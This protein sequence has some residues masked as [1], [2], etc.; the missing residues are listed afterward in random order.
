[1]VGDGVRAG[2]EAVLEQPLAQG[3]DLVLDVRRGPVGDP[4]G[5]PRTGRDR[6][7]PPER[8]RQ[9]SLATQDMDTP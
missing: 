1:V 8:Y 7:K 2:V 4:A 6:R 9:T 5:S 3:D